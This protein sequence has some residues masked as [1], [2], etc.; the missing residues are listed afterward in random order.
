MM[1]D[2]L[3]LILANKKHATFETTLTL[4]FNHLFSIYQTVTRHDIYE[5]FIPFVN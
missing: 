3:L 2:M 1:I 4:V 5:L